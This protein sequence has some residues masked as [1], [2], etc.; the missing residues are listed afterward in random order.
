MQAPG[1]ETLTLRS[2]TAS[3]L[4][5]AIAYC[6]G[7]SLRSEIEAR[8]PAGVEPATR[9]AEAALAARFGPGPIEG[10][11]SGPHRHRRAVTGFKEQT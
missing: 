10:P 1:I 5:P 9:A 4:N 3:P 6:Q 2:R 8:D 11:N 7:T